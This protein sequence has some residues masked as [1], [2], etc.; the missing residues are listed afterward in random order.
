[1]IKI[2]SKLSYYEKLKLPL[3]QRKRLEIMERDLFTCVC[4]YGDEQ[5]LNVHHHYYTKGKNPWEYPND[6]LVTLCENCHKNVEELR[7]DILKAITWEI[8]LKAIHQLATK[9]DP[10]Y[11][12]NLATAFNG[13]HGDKINGNKKLQLQQIESIINDLQNLKNIIEKE[14]K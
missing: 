11:L 1:M 7:L 4:C 13:C 9:I 2:M 3:W 14:E 10:F 12:S 5:T 6:A 8:P